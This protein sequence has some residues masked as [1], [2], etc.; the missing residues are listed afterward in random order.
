MSDT[1]VIIPAFNEEHGIASVISKIKAHAPDFDVLVIN[2][3]SADRTKAVAKEA[4]AIVLT[5]NFNMG[6][7]VAIQTGY[8]FAHEKGYSYII[9][10]D[11]DGQHD[12]TFI[13][14][15]LEPVKN[16]DVDFALGSR[17]LWFDSYRPSFTRR[18]GILFF[19]KLV[20]VIIGREITDPTSGYQ[21]FNRDVIKFFTTDVFPCDY[22][23]ADMLITLNL[24]GFRVREVPVR[25]FANP[26]GKTMHS[27]AK[28]LYYM[29]KMCLSIFVTLLR[30][31]KLYRR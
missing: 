7:G 15:L 19:R 31:R 9:Q 28:P 25:M 16:G 18:L 26:T 29:I 12:P 6:Y 3:G 11:G 13:S 21:A 30:N 14:E 8:K 1:I 22:P 24:A 10:I 2:D 17:F 27:G 20:T 23:D 4:G 5:H